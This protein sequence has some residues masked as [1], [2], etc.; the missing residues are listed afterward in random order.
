[1]D[2]MGH[3]RSPG[4]RSIVDVISSVGDHIEL[5]REAVKLGLPIFLYGHSLGGLITAGSVVNDA[6]N[7]CGVILTGPAL[8]A[9]PARLLSWIVRAMLRFA[10]EKQIFLAPAPV[11]GLS[12]LPEVIE[13][14]AND[15]LIFKGQISYTVA[16]TALQ[17]AEQLWRR[18]PQWTIPTLVIHGTD[19]TFTDPKQSTVFFQKIASA[20]KELHLIEGGRHEAL[21][22]IDSEAALTLILDWLSKRRFRVTIPKDDLQLADNVS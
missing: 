22:D 6:T 3:G 19:D 11:S 13:E 20:D 12:R 1:M 16:G 15:P 17:V 21:N 10:P 14:F 2:L 4:A 9:Q 18:L 7:I 8:A 5:R